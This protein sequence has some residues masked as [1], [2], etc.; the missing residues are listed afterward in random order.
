VSKDDL[1]K[2]V[3]DAMAKHSNLLQR[4]SA[5]SGQL[6]AKREELKTVVDEIVAAGYD[7][8][9]I[10]EAT[11]KAREDLENELEAFEAELSKVETALS[12]Y[13]K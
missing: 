2:R 3:R 5:L 4:K 9:T 11:Q 12:T 6:Q 1:S 7:P 10:R 13:D 8:R